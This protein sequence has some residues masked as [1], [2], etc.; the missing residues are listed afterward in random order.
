[1]SRHK[2]GSKSENRRQKKVS[3]KAICIIYLLFISIGILENLKPGYNNTYICLL[4]TD[5]I[6]CCIYDLD[7]YCG[8]LWLK[9]EIAD[10]KFTFKLFWQFL[11][12]LFEAILQF[13]LP[14]NL[15]I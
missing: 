4:S 15:I 10:S 5:I 9:I 3:F 1:M 11:Q 7:I 6:W 14:P 8:V 2:I 12:L 13:Q